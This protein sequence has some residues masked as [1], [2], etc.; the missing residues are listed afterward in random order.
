MTMHRRSILASAA[1]IQR[2][3]AL[4]VVLGHGVL[5]STKAMTGASVELALGPPI[6]PIHF[7]K[8]TLR[9]LR[10]RIAGCGRH[11]GAPRRTRKRRQRLPASILEISARWT[12]VRRR[13]KRRRT[14]SPPTTGAR[15]T[16]KG[17]RRRKVPSMIRPLMW[18]SALSG[19]LWKNLLRKLGTLGAQ[20][21]KVRKK[22]GR[23]KMNPYLSLRLLHLSPLTNGGLLARR[24]RRRKVRRSSRRR[25]R[26]QK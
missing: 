9:I 1:L 6:S 16:R 24:I 10:L 20:P 17:R 15:S 22:L 23:K 11:L 14:I 8:P 7:R 3:R 4:V 5:T 12:R 25:S 21:L 19:K 26:S 2:V 13:K 18:T